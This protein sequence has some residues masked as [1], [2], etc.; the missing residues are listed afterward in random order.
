MQ[1]CLQE[2]FKQNSN[3][4]T[5]TGH[6]KNTDY[7]KNLCLFSTA[8][9]RAPD[10]SLTIKHKNICS[11]TDPC[12][13][14]GLPDT[15]GVTWFFVYS[16]TSLIP[17]LFSVQA[18]TQK[19]VGWRIQGI[20]V[21]QMFSLQALVW[22]H[23]NQKYRCNPRASFRGDGTEPSSSQLGVSSTN[24]L[25]FMHRQNF[26]SHSFSRLN[27]H[28]SKRKI[29]KWKARSSQTAEIN[30]SHLNSARNNFP[31]VLWWY[32]HLHGETQCWVSLWEFTEIK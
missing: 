27:I 14:L 28:Q 20:Q 15:A 17:F 24:E 18:Y 25:P 10:S 30:H 12:S 31:F 22:L 11:S 1:F 5:I 8:M 16:Q 6:V 7:S 23:Q 26:S 9:P 13:K 32:W 29:M 3:V 19:D 21:I 4:L 2:T